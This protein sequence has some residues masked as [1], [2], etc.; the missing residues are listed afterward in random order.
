MEFVRV[1]QLHDI[2]RTNALPSFVSVA[3]L[4]KA[5]VVIDV[6]DNKTRKET[7]C[8]SIAVLEQIVDWLKEPID[9]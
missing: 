7:I 6:T 1:K 8:L 3:Q 4:D 5:F 2:S 9:D